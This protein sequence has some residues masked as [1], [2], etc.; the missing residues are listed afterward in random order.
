MT[1][2]NI[3]NLKDFDYDLPLERIAQFPLPQRDKSK[4]L[5]FKNGIIKE[6]VFSA[7]NTYIPEDSFLVFNNTKVINAR[8]FFRKKTGAKIEIF[9]L[10]PSGNKTVEIAFS[11]KEYSNWICLVGNAS[12]WTDEI[13]EKEIFVNGEKCILYAEKIRAVSGNFEIRFS[14]SLKALTF[15]EIIHEAG[16]I[17][18]PP[19]IKRTPEKDDSERYQTVY[20]DSEGS[21]AAPTAGLHFTEEILIEFGKKG[22]QYD[23]LTLNVGAGTFKPIKEE[24]V[25]NH[26]MHFESFSVKK[27]F[28]EKLLG[29]SGSNIVAVGTTSVRTLESLYWMYVL[30]KHKT[31]FVLNQWEVYNYN[32]KDFPDLKT[33][34]KGLIDHLDDINEDTINGSTELMIIPGYKYKVVDVLITNFHMPC[35]SLLLL[36]SAFTGENWK[37]IYEYAL[38]NNFRFLSYGDSSILFKQ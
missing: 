5:V 7:I 35:S 21:V 38:A 6:S 19:Y 28:L 27:S 24:N 4:L 25:F 10:E 13:L 14:W 18:L 12:K 34:L 33:V 23:Y 20:A 29:Y 9:C 22:I 3:L 17:P 8:L 37:K 31:G 32:E 1:P 15:S 26:S 2:D 16:L 30:G 11:E 36:V